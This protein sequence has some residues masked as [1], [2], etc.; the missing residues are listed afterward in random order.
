[1]GADEEDIVVGEG[2]EPQAKLWKQPLNLVCQVDAAIYGSGGIAR[3]AEAMV[4]GLVAYGQR[5]KL[6]W[7]KQD[8][9]AE[10]RDP[11]DESLERLVY[12]PR[13]VKF[14]KRRGLKWLKP[15]ASRLE[16]WSGEREA[17]RLLAKSDLY[18]SMCHRL[19]DVP[20]SKKIVTIHDA[21]AALTDRYH[22]PEEIG[23]FSKFLSRV[24]KLADLIFVPSEATKDDLVKRLKFNEDKIEVLPSP[25]DEIF[26]NPPD[27]LPEPDVRRPYILSV[28]TLGA[29]KD[30]AGLL[31]AYGTFRREVG[32][33]VLLVLVGRRLE[34]SRLAELVASS[35][36][37]DDIVHTGF[38]DDATLVAL[39]RNASI[40][41]YPS[42]AEGFG[43]PVAEAMALG[44]PIIAYRL[45]SIEQMTENRAAKLV[46]AGDSDALAKAMLEVWHS[47][48][49]A[50][51]LSKHGRMFAQRFAPRKLAMRAVKLI[52]DRLVAPEV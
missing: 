48:E 34:S 12:T 28:G 37:S 38:I 8:A 11:F 21:I 51:R 19:Y 39:Y 43:Y 14:G 40:F 16:R 17:K 47:T 26:L 20:G 7:V 50:E 1:M 15:V 44:A 27:E 18:W 41:C 25:L 52:R 4:A 24:R 31:N 10:R 36:F 33:R 49:L 6:F 5:P 42:L 46:P 3:Y 23:A 45:P 9:P 35:A 29:R 13:P 30:L 2:A 32:E 22:S